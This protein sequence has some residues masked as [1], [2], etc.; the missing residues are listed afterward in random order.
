MFVSAAPFVAGVEPRVAP[1]SLLRGACVN[2]IWTRAPGRRH[3]VQWCPAL[4]AGARNCSMGRHWPRCVSKLA[5]VFQ[6]PHALSSVTQCTQS[7]GWH[8]WAFRNALS[9]VAPVMWVWQVP[10][11]GAPPPNH[12]HRTDP[13]PTAPKAPGP[14]LSSSL[15]RA[16]RN[17]D[18]IAEGPGPGQYFNLRIGTQGD[19][20][21]SKPRGV[22]VVRVVRHSALIPVVPAIVH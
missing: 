2:R 19:A 12:Y 21:L 14:G 15:P 20:S 10:V 4:T 17:P 1:A 8:P 9:V 11:D 7:V 13:G 18:P 5:D 22:T 6:T 16:P 3:L